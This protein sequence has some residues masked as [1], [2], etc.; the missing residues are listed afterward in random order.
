MLA[1]SLGKRVVPNV[2]TE[3]H[4]EKQ[5]TQH[6]TTTCTRRHARQRQLQQ[7]ERQRR[8]VQ[9]HVGTRRRGTSSSRPVR[10]RL[11][12]SDDGEVR[13]RR[14]ASW[15]SATLTRLARGDVE[16]RLFGSLATSSRLFTSITEQRMHSKRLE[17]LSDVPSSSDRFDSVSTEVDCSVRTQLSNCAV[18]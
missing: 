13:Q 14:H 5:N 12:A 6:T 4:K 8:L 15:F 18:R 10:A 17:A 7:L 9:R 3:R 1:G 16:L 2:R 11:D